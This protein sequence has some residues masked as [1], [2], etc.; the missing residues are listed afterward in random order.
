[1][2]YSYGDAADD[3]LL[4]ARMLHLSRLNNTLQERVEQERLDRPFNWRRIDA[5]NVA[6]DFPV[7]GEEELRSLTLGAYQLKLASSYSQEHICDGAYEMLVHG[8]FENIVCA[9]IQSRHVEA[10]QYKCWI[11]YRD[12]AVVAWYCKC[13]PGSRVVGMC[14][15]LTSVIWYLAYQRHLGSQ[16]RKGVQNWSTHFINAKEQ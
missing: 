2:F 9:K 3:Q 1:M 16:Q 13:R 15:H 7:Y 12:G 14:A 10:K 4:A 5:D 11:E 8:E 6:A